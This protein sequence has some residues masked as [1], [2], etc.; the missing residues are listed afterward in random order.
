MPWVWPSACPPWALS[1]QC[2]ENTVSTCISV[3]GYKCCWAFDLDKLAIAY[4]IRFLIE[5]HFLYLIS[6]VPERQ[7]FASASCA[8]PGLNSVY[9]WVIWI[10]IFWSW[11]SVPITHCF[12][13]FWAW[14]QTMLAHCLVPSKCLWLKTRKN[15]AF[16]GPTCT[17]R[18]QKRRAF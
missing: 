18:K 7:I 1:V 6:S 8:Y 14:I 10:N 13:I 12:L 5:H 15:K 4:E 2:C 9:L 16:F 11:D 17:H 3:M